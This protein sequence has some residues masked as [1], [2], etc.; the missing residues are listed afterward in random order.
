MALAGHHPQRCLSQALGK[1]SGGKYNDFSANRHCRLGREETPGQP[2]R[3]HRTRRTRG[4]RETAGLILPGA[5]LPVAWSS[6]MSGSDPRAR[7]ETKG[8]T[9]RP[10]YELKLQ[11][12]HGL[13][14]TRGLPSEV[15][16]T[17]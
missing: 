1:I 12:R 5:H 8:Q 15:V 10:T 14:T 6:E 2:S 16:A 17:L 11:K 3:D 4:F 7:A 9:P 13:R